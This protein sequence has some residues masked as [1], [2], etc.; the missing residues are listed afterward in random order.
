MERQK[1]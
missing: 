1:G